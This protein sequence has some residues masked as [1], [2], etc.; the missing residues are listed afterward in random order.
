[1]K[2][3]LIINKRAIRTFLGEH[4]HPKLKIII[5]S[6]LNILSNIIS[7]IRQ[8][9]DFF[10][11]KRRKKIWL[12]K[13]EIDN[14]K[15]NIKI[16]D[17]FLFFNEL[18]LLEIRLNILEKYVDYFVLIEATETF[19]GL[20]KKLYYEEN[21]NLFKKW[22]H[23]IIHYIVKDTPKNEADLKNRLLNKNLSNLEKEIINNTLTTENVPDKSQVQWL[24]EFYQ[25]ESTIKALIELSDND[26]CFVSDLDEIWNPEILI[27]YSQDNIFKFKQ[28]AYVYFLNNR[29][30]E[31][32]GG[33]VSTIATK[34]KNIKKFGIN[35]IRTRNKNKFAILRNGGW[36]FTFQGG[37][38]RVRTKLESY[39]HQEINTT[40]IKSQMEN[41]ISENK[42]IRGR[43]IKFW[44]DESRL[45]KYLL[46]NKEKYKKLFK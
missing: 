40:E 4:T 19:T 5:K 46:D 31:N 7:Y 1:M 35:H 43:H 8:P 9:I 34:Y 3:N 39:S 27:D 41:I 11:E 15:K 24:K 36:H 25:K 2:K 22:E 23:K 17:I 6:I 26:F 37:A 10:I 16:Y 28:D 21:K 33:G 32:W 38:D 30:N 18:E 42:D 45:P 13:K 44:K 20:P 14:Y 29:S 12:S